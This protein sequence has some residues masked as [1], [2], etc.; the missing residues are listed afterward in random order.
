MRRHSPMRCRTNVE[1]GK[2]SIPGRATLRANASVARPMNLLAQQRRLL[3]MD[4]I[5]IGMGSVWAARVGMHL[6]TRRSRAGNAPP[7][8][9]AV[10]G[11]STYECATVDKHSVDVDD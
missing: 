6:G 10:E 1:A 11:Y 8:H 4:E 3:K 7:S 5:G 9:A 2:I